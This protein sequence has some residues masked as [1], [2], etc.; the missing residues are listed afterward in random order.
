M[1][2]HDP[3]YVVIPRRG[4]GLAS[5]VL[6]AALTAA[7]V[8]AGTVIAIVQSG[9]LPALAS[10]TSA[11]RSAPGADAVRV[12]DVVGMAAENADEILSA[13]KLRFVVKGRQ[14]HPTAAAGSVIEQS[15]FAQSRVQP[16]DEVS[17]VLS[18][19]PD[20]LK[21]PDVI[22][23]SLEDAQRALDAAGLHAGSVMEV[24]SGDPGKVTAVSPPPGSEI[25]R[26]ASVS[27]AVARPK[28]AV[29]RVGGEHVRAARERIK[30]AG[31]VVGDV[32]EIYDSRKKGNV[33]LSQEP[34]AGTAVPLGARINLVI[35]QG[36]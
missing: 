15:P 20:R 31:L 2:E 32:S 14:T 27:L 25:E 24:D 30:K 9:A 35:N 19:G 21:V 5:V 1:R 6:V 4:P 26:G 8:S 33:V 29:P 22:G 7:L 18:T 11:G 23:Q 3:N 17:V 16:G 34:E 12:P 36:D 10:L 28:V 13:R